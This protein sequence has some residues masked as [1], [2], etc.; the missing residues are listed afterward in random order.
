MQ[1]CRRTA[2]ALAALLALRRPPPAD[3]PARAE[4]RAHRGHGAGCRPVEAPRNRAVRAARQGVAEAPRRPTSGSRTQR[5]TAGHAAHEIR[6]RRRRRALH[7]RADGRLGGRERGSTQLTRR[8]R[9]P[10][11][12][13][14]VHFDTTTTT[15]PHSLHHQPSGGKSYAGRP[16]ERR[17]SWGNGVHAEARSTRPGGRRRCASPSAAP[18]PAKACRVGDAGVAKWSAERELRW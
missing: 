13:R 9:G 6:W 16:G 4:R 10:A 8:D 14:A 2:A 12:T 18:L 1:T 15:P 17:P 3:H 7:R 11:A 5:G